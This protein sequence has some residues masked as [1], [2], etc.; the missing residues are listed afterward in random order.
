ML[1]RLTAAIFGDGEQLGVPTPGHGGNLFHASPATSQAPGAP[2]RSI[3]TPP[4]IHLS[5][6]A[7]WRPLPRPSN[8]SPQV[9]TPPGSLQPDTAAAFGIRKVRVVEEPCVV[10]S[11]AV[12]ESCPTSTEE[13]SQ[14]REPPTCPALHGASR[15][16]Q[17]DCFPER[18][19]APDSHLHISL[20]ENRNPS[21]EQ[22]AALLCAC[23]SGVRVRK[24]LG[25]EQLSESSQISIS[26]GPLAREEAAHQPERRQQLYDD[27]SGEARLRANSSDR[28][29]GS[30]A[31]YPSA[32]TV[33]GNPK[34]FNLRQSLWPWPDTHAPLS[35]REAR[36][37]SAPATKVSQAE[38]AALAQAPLAVTSPTAGPR[39]PPHV[40]SPVSARLSPCS[41]SSDPAS[42]CICASLPPDSQG[43]AAPPAAT[44][45]QALSAAPKALGAYARA[46]SGRPRAAL[47]HGTA[48]KK[49]SALPTRG[50][51]RTPANH[52]LPG[53]RPVKPS[54]KPSATSSRLS[55]SAGARSSAPHLPPLRNAHVLLA[56]TPAPP[57]SLDGG[58]A[59]RETAAT[60]PCRSRET[61]VGRQGAAPRA[62][63]AVLAEQKQRARA[64]TKGQTAQADA[65]L[66][67][68]PR[69]RSLSLSS[70]AGVSAGPPH[71]RSHSSAPALVSQPAATRPQ[72]RQRRNG[73]SADAD[74]RRD[75][76]KP[77]RP[78]EPTSASRRE[79]MENHR[80]DGQRPTP[81][82]RSAGPQEGLTR[83]GNELRACTR[84]PPETR[85]APVWRQGGSQKNLEETQNA[86]A[87]LQASAQELRERLADT[88]TERGR[89]RTRGPLLPSTGWRGRSGDAPAAAK[90]R[91][92]GLAKVGRCVAR[93]GVTTDERRSLTRICGAT[94]ETTST[95]RES[96][97]TSATPCA[98][99]AS[100]QSAAELDSGAEAR[101]RPGLA[102]G[103]AARMPS[104]LD[105]N[106]RQRERLAQDSGRERHKGKNDGCEGGARGGRDAQSVEVD[107]ASVAP[108]TDRPGDWRQPRN[109]G[110]RRSGLSSDSA[111]DPRLDAAATTLKAAPGRRES[112][113]RGDGRVA[114]GTDT[115]QEKHAV[116]R[117]SPGSD[118]SRVLTSSECQEMLWSD[119]L[120][121][122][123][124][125]RPGVFSTPE[126]SPG[127]VEKQRMVQQLRIQELGDASVET[128]TVCAETKMTTASKSA[129]P[130]ASFDLPHLS[131][132]SLASAPPPSAWG[133]RGRQRRP[134]FESFASHPSCVTSSPCLS[135][136][137][138]PS[139]SLLPPSARR[140]FTPTTPEQW[141]EG[142]E[143]AKA[144][145]SEGASAR[146]QEILLRD[147]AG[148]I[149]LF[150]L[151]SFLAAGCRPATS[152]DSQW[153]WGPSS[154]T[155]RKRGLDEAAS[156]PS[157]PERYV[158]PRP[159]ARAPPR[160]SS[161]SS[162]RPAA[163]VSRQCG[164]CGEPDYT[165]IRLGPTSPAAATNQA[166][167]D[168]S[169]NT[170]GAARGAR[171]AD[172]A[173]RGAPRE[174]NS[175]PGRRE[176]LGREGAFFDAFASCQVRRGEKGAMQKDRLDVFDPGREEE[177]AGSLPHLLS[178]SA[179]RVSGVVPSADRLACDLKP[180]ASVGSERDQTMETR[181]SAVDK[182]SE[183]GQ[184]LEGGSA[185]RGGSRPPGEQGARPRAG[186]QAEHVRQVASGTLQFRLASSTSE[187]DNT[188]EETDFLVAASNPHSSTPSGEYAD[189]AHFFFTEKGSWTG[190]RSTKKLAS[191]RSCLPSHESPWCCRPSWPSLEARD[192]RS[193]LPS[194]S[195]TGD[196]PLSE[197][198][199]TAPSQPGFRGFLCGS[200]ASSSSVC[201]SAGVRVNTLQENYG[202]EASLA[203]S[204]ASSEI[205]HSTHTASGAHLASLKIQ[206]EAV[207]LT[208][209]LCTFASA[210]A[211]F[212]RSLERRRARGET[213][214]P[215]GNTTPRRAF[216]SAILHDFSL[217]ERGR[218]VPDIER[219][220]FSLL[221]K[222]PAAAVAD[223]GG[224]ARTSRY[225]VSGREK[226]GR[227]ES[228]SW[229]GAG[230]GA[231]ED[232]DRPPRKS[233]LC[234]GCSYIGTFCELE[235]AVA[236][237]L[238][239]ADVLRYSLGFDIVR[240]LYTETR[241]G[242]AVAEETLHSPTKTNILKHL[243]ALVENGRAGD[244]LVF[245]F[246]G[247][248]VQLAP[249]HP[250][251]AP[252]F[253][254]AALLPEDFCADRG[255]A[256]RLLA[257]AE[258]RHLISAVAPGVQ[259]CLILDCG[260]AHLLLPSLASCYFSAESL[261]PQAAQE[262]PAGAFPQLDRTG[263]ETDFS[264]GNAAQDV[265]ND[266]SAAASQ[267]S[268]LLSSSAFSRPDS[269]AAGSSLLFA[270][271]G[272]FASSSAFPAGSARPPHRGLPP[273]AARG[274][275]YRPRFKSAGVFPCS[276]LPRSS[277]GQGRPLHAL[278]GEAVPS[279]LLS[280]K[281]FSE[282]LGSAQADTKD[283]STASVFAF[284][285]DE[286]TPA[287]EVLLRG[288]ERPT[289]WLTHR[290]L[291]ALQ[292]LPAGA[293]YFDVGDHAA[294]ACLHLQPSMHLSATGEARSFGMQYARMGAFQ[295]AE[296]FRL[297][298]TPHT[299]PHSCAFLSH[300]PA[301]SSLFP[302]SCR[303]Y[304]YYVPPSFAAGPIS[305]QASV[306]RL[307][308]PNASCAAER[309]CRRS[310]ECPHTASARASSSA[311]PRAS[312]SALTS[313]S[314]SGR[315]LL[316]CA[317]PSATLSDSSS[318][319]LSSASSALARFAPC[320]PPQPRL[321]ELPAERVS[322]SRALSPFLAARPLSPSC[323]PGPLDPPCGAR[324]L[325]RSWESASSSASARP[326]QRSS[327]LTAAAWAASPTPVCEQALRAR[328]CRARL[329][330]RRAVE[331]VASGGAEQ[332]QLKSDAALT[333]CA[334]L[335]EDCVF[336][337]NGIW[338]AD[339][340]LGH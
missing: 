78:K 10:A 63:E 13:S 59:P 163:S 232:A 321:W 135:V 151:P 241:A 265:R 97:L 245:F 107:S 3:G 328:E 179:F 124:Q 216:S 45:S 21:C 189:P 109:V 104:A 325:R 168:P 158:E 230:A 196:S 48:A 248:G 5:P 138:Y 258:L 29:L 330:W 98:A 278:A 38:R 140:S 272:P 146:E 150:R 39:M 167:E 1:A 287:A 114:A 119:G 121:P 260:Q 281:R 304:P 173:S 88:R 249:E 298:F 111:A 90:T 261:S 270:A 240:C 259:V 172:V 271:S 323:S 266:L 218:D 32:S 338:F 35:S 36:D 149:H 52:G 20:R 310:S 27:R 70:Y 317:A 60:A 191:P 277:E 257:G 335:E 25:G 254:E 34:R 326:K 103:T 201:A 47:A 275:Q 65:C 133:P 212:E 131:S 99:P 81:W 94:E 198:A 192:A 250:Y 246:S 126:E 276:P 194:S 305:R 176:E 231:D 160:R 300:E 118:L 256:K 96:V 244:V 40:C 31:I 44:S 255:S 226:S 294:T 331:S 295:G 9:R 283:S 223:G 132:A 182:T 280:A 6:H 234:V 71:A 8:A 263:T 23:G 137:P 49:P 229:F 268:T 214:L 188:G 204:L 197:V 110:T 247:C 333:R 26:S 320:S 136:T 299:P 14:T 51:A 267:A 238:A 291:T 264:S 100:P 210:F 169:P 76:G 239:F 156:E 301:V 19:R 235:G 69:F 308:A 307:F 50:D 120:L 16:C 222:P 134:V 292:T 128:R 193:P 164:H 106:E 4:V 143:E 316:F 84:C 15:P 77:G 18:N 22:R 290:L 92:L 236:D 159:R 155:P 293:S 93:A 170:G 75:P 183:K 296:K 129:T 12:A 286:Q 145:G 55:S 142:A 174:G 46:S 41:S 64:T 102:E 217:S 314:G 68:P 83:N 43:P 233:A 125:S 28:P 312:H 175:A 297:C 161:R 17:P 313:A 332:T 329:L 61:T 221:T 162:A 327:P 337:V 309:P 206:S 178:P 74:A 105:L 127:D 57:R 11:P 7:C 209:E 181:E 95:Q 53:L 33:L 56:D 113:R 2:F 87:D 208:G 274:L 80:Q 237:C 228:S 115:A 148:S 101:K 205:R 336:T 42:P 185:E 54:G 186:A 225:E 62:Q 227:V 302:V 288:A 153:T 213:Q 202:C 190:T 91:G 306:G 207:S 177:P 184:R 123:E 282:A 203:S 289:G 318:A 273:P 322:C 319:S 199:K 340:M 58:Q 219:L 279:L 73:T 262:R 157:D 141:E 85:E 144:R 122:G 166:A 24:Q 86:A 339:G 285:P 303:R 180:P 30:K 251:F 269:N 116:D 253:P 252:H 220:E 154:P 315:S 171:R 243:S 147:S 79:W 72:P 284:I 311:S 66:H 82:T 224:P 215:Q 324:L 211:P 117:E 108:G 200:S 195:F 187:A 152:P 130:A 139:F 165:D 37:D 334:A 242:A 89:T 112:L 67:S